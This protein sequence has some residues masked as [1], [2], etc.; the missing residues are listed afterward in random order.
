MT[1]DD[2]T[3]STGV[4]VTAPSMLYSIVQPSG[5]S[6]PPAVNFIP[7]SKDVRSSRSL[8]PGVNRPETPTLTVVPSSMTDPSRIG[9]PPTV[10]AI[11]ALG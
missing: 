4:Q 2:G 9:R 5:A 6:A 7:G 10:T 11:S 8:V 3:G 1:S